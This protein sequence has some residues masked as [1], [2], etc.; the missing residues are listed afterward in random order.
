[1]PGDT[2]ISWAD[3]TWNPTVGCTKPTLP[4][5]AVSEGCRHC[6]AAEL[7]NQRHIAYQNGQLQNVPQYARPFHQ[8]QLLPE[9]LLIP[10]RWTKPQRIFV[11]S[12]SDLLHEDVPDAFLD[13][14][15]A[16]MFLAADVRG[17]VF[18]VLTKR[19]QRLQAYLTHPGRRALIAAAMAALPFP[20]AAPA[21]VTFRDATGPLTHPG[22][23]LGTSTEHQAAAEAR[24]PA[25]LATPAAV[26]F[27]SCEPL[28]GE[29]DLLPWLHFDHCPEELDPAAYGTTSD[30]ACS[31]CEGQGVMPHSECHARMTA[32][33]HW[34]IA[35]GESG[36]HAR[37]MQPDW[38]RLL[39]DRCA[40]AGVA[41]HFKQ[42]GTFDERGRRTSSGRSWPHRTL[43][44]AHHDA[45]PDPEG[46]RLDDPGTA[47]L[48]IH[49]YQRGPL[50]LKQARAL[51]P[52]APEWQVWAALEGL[53]RSGLAI[54]EGRA[55][56]AGMDEDAARRA[57]GRLSGE[58][59]CATCGCTERWAC[60]E[61][62]WWT[63]DHQCS[64]CGPAHA[65][66]SVP[67]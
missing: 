66:V 31:G 67:Q 30:E 60:P 8:L 51:L 53:T 56:H 14:A 46:G 52:G 20:G 43:D 36:R 4:G 34:V 57:Y 54:H 19:P 2:E 41:F 27:L 17:H 35:G 59:A 25:L 13:R 22:L 9:R 40:S 15:F 28:L 5:G 45:Y 39:R 64:T 58:R 50:T 26:R 47:A 18:Q 11:N 3:R 32:T 62:C 44:G 65:L 38:A 42:W 37:P 63:A 49:L 23:W 1:M 55:Y 33:L 29:L 16:V 48:L 10:L 12:V 21:S 7:H 24:V 6:Y 61:G